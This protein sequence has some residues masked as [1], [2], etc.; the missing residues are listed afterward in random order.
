MRHNWEA[1]VVTVFQATRTHG[2]HYGARWCTD[3]TSHRK[4]DLQEGAAVHDQNVASVPAD[5]AK[6]EQWTSDLKKMLW[7]LMKL[8]IRYLIVRLRYRPSSRRFLNEWFQMCK[9]IYKHSWCLVKGLILHPNT[10]TNI[11]AC[12]SQS[13]FVLP[14]C[15]SRA[16]CLISQQ[17]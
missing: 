17:N 5:C 11:P 4:P 3:I 6:R 16:S 12:D 8:R 14:L 15:F 13:D 2:M 1:V 9:Q 7:W 10:A